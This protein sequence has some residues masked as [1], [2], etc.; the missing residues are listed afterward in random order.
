MKW[1]KCHWGGHSIFVL[2]G[3]YA[4]QVVVDPANLQMVTQIINNQ[5]TPLHSPMLKKWQ[6]GKITPFLLND[7]SLYGSGGNDSG[8]LGLN[9]VIPDLAHSNSCIWCKKYFCGKNHTGC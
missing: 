1:Q 7:G 4:Q 3:D 6:P 8:Q 9:H 5:T 2:K